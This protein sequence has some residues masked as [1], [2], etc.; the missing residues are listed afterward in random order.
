MTTVAA[1]PGQLVLDPTDS[2]RL[3]NTS[4]TEFDLD[5]VNKDWKNEPIK[6]S[7]TFTYTWARRKY[8]VGPGETLTVPWDIVRLNFGDPRSVNEVYQKYEDQNGEQGD[9][10]PR[11]REV[12]RLCVLHGI[13]AGNEIR[14]P[15]CHSVRYI[16]I[17][18][19]DGQE[20]FCPAVDIDGSIS[21]GHR[22]GDRDV[23][24]PATM[25]ATMKAQ[26]QRMQ[27]QMDAMNGNNPDLVNDVGRDQPRY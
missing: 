7:N 19:M 12:A 11:G 20:I 26:M 24:D 1:S 17:R 27:E 3:T 2:F 16:T 21:Y 15:E 14:L 13:Y 18:T 8:I 22:E 6:L 25:M 4:T 10:P 23:Q 5:E 9:I